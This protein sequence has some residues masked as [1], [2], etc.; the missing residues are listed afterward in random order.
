MSC[1]D[2]CTLHHKSDTWQQG[3]ECEGYLSPAEWIVQSPAPLGAVHTMDAKGQEYRLLGGG[4]PLLRVIALS[5][6][7]SSA[8]QLLGA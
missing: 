3:K 8:W 1:R 7:L 5:A 4:L 2:R 6:R